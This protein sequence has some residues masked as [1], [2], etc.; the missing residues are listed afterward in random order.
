[1]A[2][3]TELLKICSIISF[4]YNVIGGLNPND[5]ETVY[6]SITLKI[7][8]EK[9]YSK[10]DFKKIYPSDESFESAFSNKAFKLSTRNHSIVRYI[11]GKIESNI[12]HNEIDYSSEKYSIEHILPESPG[13]G[14]DNV[15][16]DSLER[17]VYRLGNLSLLEKGLNNKCGNKSFE[18]KKGYYKKSSVGIMKLISEEYNEWNEE[19]IIQHQSWM[20]KQAKS[21]WKIS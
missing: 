5:Q 11:L 2:S 12:F 15:P 6:N 18:E 19:K 16:N 7:L 4:R 10:N 17:S 8:E 3:F 9:R 13:E 21:I 1:L 14:W 20:A